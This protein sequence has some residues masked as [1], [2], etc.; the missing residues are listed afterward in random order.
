MS[1]NV[2]TVMF[3]IEGAMRLYARVVKKLIRIGISTS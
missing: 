1:P 3:A 2:S